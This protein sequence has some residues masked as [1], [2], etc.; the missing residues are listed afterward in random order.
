[1]KKLF[2]IMSLCL[3]TLTACGQTKSGDST[4]KS[5]DS[6]NIQKYEV[7][8]FDAFDTVNTFQVYDTSEAKANEYIE[9]M[10]DE[11]FKYNREFDRYNSYEGLNNLKTVNDN[12]GK[13]PV[14][15]NDDLFDLVELTLEREKT[16]SN[17]VNI[18]MGPVIDVWT[19]YRDA[20][21]EGGEAEAVRKYGH[22]LPTTEELEALRPLLDT[23]KIKLDKNEKTIYIE[24]GMILDLGAVA[25]GY[26][27]EKVG[28]Y[29][30]DIGVKAALISAGGNVKLVGNHPLKETFNVAIQNPYNKD[31]QNNFLAV[32]KLNDT[33]VVTS[34]D[35]QR[36]F[37][38]NGKRYHHIIDPM[39]L[40]PSE[41]YN[42]V[43]IVTKDS[44][45][46]DFLSTAMFLSS[47]DEIRK[48]GKEQNVEI[49][50]NTAS[51][52]L[53]ETGNML[54]E[55]NEK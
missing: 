40:Q 20:H 35:Y 14:K 18:A 4:D 43:S 22:P 39:T 50:W 32:L 5:A 15:V 52:E 41:N 38:Y 37:D 8:F 46:S 54:E 13:Q 27:A 55:N 21:I 26:A 11:Y 1:M 7:Q 2:I 17:K 31:D 9:K 45:L 24:S 49:I 23:S 30:R 36:Y 33:S 12:A 44:G 16:I 19:K 3:F 48:V 6:A 34:G 47:E 51:G 25:K 42:S 28:E 29:A 10:R 53:K